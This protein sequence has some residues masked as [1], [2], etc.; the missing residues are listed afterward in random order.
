MNE[1]VE[2]WISRYAQPLALILL[3]GMMFLGLQ[4][5]TFLLRFPPHERTTFWA[6]GALTFTAL[7]LSPWQQWWRYYVGLCIGAYLAFYKDPEIPESTALFAAQFH[8]ATVAAGVYA[9]RRI[10][11]QKPFSTL[12][13]MVVFVLTAGVAVPLAT[14]IPTELAN[15][16]QSGSIEWPVSI[17]TFLCVAL[18]MVIA[19]PAFATA[20]TETPRWV[21]QAK[22]GKLSEAAILALLLLLVTGLVFTARVDIQALPALIYVPIPILLWAT[23]RFGVAGASWALLCIAYLSTATAINGMGPFVD[24]T[25]DDHVLQLQLFLLALSLPLLIMATIVQERRRSHNLFVEEY[26]SRRKLENRIRLVVESTPNAIAI[27]HLDGS[28]ALVNQPIERWFGFSRDELLGSSLQKLLPE[29]FHSSLKHEMEACLKSSTSHKPRVAEYLGLRKDRS[30]FPLEMSFVPLDEGTSRL[31]LICMLDLTERRKSEEARRELVHANRLATVSE[32]TASIAHELNQPLAA[33]LSNAEAGELM[34]EESQPALEE[35][36]T[37]LADIR[38]DDLR[39]SEVIRKLRNLMRR[40]EMEKSS[41][42]I[43]TLIN[44]VIAIVRAE[45]Q[46]KR[47]EVSLSVPTKAL[48]VYGDRTHL[49]QVLLNLVANGIEAMAT[50]E[51]PRKLHIATTTADGFAKFTVTDTGPGIAAE[52]LQRIFERFYSTKQDGMGIGLAIAKSLIEEHGGEI[53]VESG[54]GQGAT[55]GFKIP[56]EHNGDHGN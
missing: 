43:D 34:L 19:T 38:N 2:R 8:F 56:L 51:H 21:Q 37:I 26:E 49:Q 7:L 3:F 50:S 42:C 41:I 14:T 4:K 33:I 15:W 25:V 24:G 18:G 36:K 12:S 9:M 35:L 28:L 22:W 48:H 16:F 5:L 44:E 47:I 20:V 27:A 45:A 11:A 17:R 53:W 23:I 31:A 55:F 10:T 29:R 46:R 54:E 13:A 52:N 6:P 39:A 30:E 40:G 1:R 32:L